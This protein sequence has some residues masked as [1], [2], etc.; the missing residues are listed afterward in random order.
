MRGEAADES[1]RIHA[2]RQLCSSRHGEI[3]VKAIREGW[4]VQRV[5]LE[6]LRASRP[7]A[8]LMTSHSSAHTDVTVIEAAVLAH[9]GHESIAEKHLGAQAAQHARDL[10]VTSLVDLCRAALL[11]DGRPAPNG[12][13]AMIHAA[14]STISLPV[15]LGNAANK[16]LLDAYMEA[17]ATWRKFAAIKSAGD[18]KDHTGIR[19]SQTGDLDPVAPGGELTHGSMKEATYKFSIDT[20][21]K[22]ISLDRRDIINDDLGFFEDTAMSLGRAAMRSLS[23]L[24]FK[25]LLTNE[26]GFFGSGNNNYDVGP[27]TELG[28]ETLANGVSRM[29][30]QRDEEHRDLDIRPRTLLVPPELQWLAKQLLQSDYLQRLAESQ[31]TGNAMKGIV[32]L[33]VE[34]RLSNPHRFKYTNP[35][36][37]YLFGSPFDAPI[38]VAFLQGK[39]TPTVEFFGLDSEPNRL[40]ASWRVY[41][42]YGCALGDFRAAYKA[43]GEA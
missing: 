18:F 17:P 28:I 41:F 30:S 22:M 21:G 2:I 38:V 11:L 10:R 26:G 33:E 12:R 31:P 7:T 40:A 39:Q 36:S 3:E 29:L 24:V 6:V 16:V 20:F 43:K 9:M 27:D 4:D 14:L 32:N 13:E 42:D 25:V 34:P 15:A 23:D 1:Q 8:P 35:K 19:P 37:W 5:E